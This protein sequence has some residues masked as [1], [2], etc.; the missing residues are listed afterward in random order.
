MLLPGGADSWGTSSRPEQ[1][2]GASRTSPIANVI[3]ARLYHRSVNYE[4]FMGEALAEAGQGGEAGERPIGVVA[5]VDEAMVARARERVVEMDDP[6]A[7]AVILA[8]RE[9]SRRLG[10]D[11]LADATIFSTLEPCAMCIGALLQADVG[12]LVYAA[13]NGRD[14]AAGSVVQLAQHPDLPHRLRVISGIRRDE[15]DRLFS[16]TATR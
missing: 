13:P 1:T 10:R 3:F 11:R 16:V 12:S 7:H 14:G 5:V 8:L 9:A 2:T 6:T 4:L 15:A